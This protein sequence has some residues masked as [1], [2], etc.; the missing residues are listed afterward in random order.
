MSTTACSHGS[1]WA[2]YPQQEEP[3]SSEVGDSEAKNVGCLHIYMYIFVVYSPAVSRMTTFYRRVLLGSPRPSCDTTDCCFVD[4]LFM[5][6]NLFCWMAL[7]LFLYIYIPFLPGIK[8][9]LTNQQRSLYYTANSN[10][11]R[12]NLMLWILRS[13]SL[14][15]PEIDSVT[16]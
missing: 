9:V 1:H 7:C 8:R 6:F 5:W 15:F 3:A 14:H 10:A 12:I 11:E 13:P 16:L 4:W 2:M